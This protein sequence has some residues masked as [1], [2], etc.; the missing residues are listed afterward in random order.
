MAI[1][2]FVFLGIEFNL[3]RHHWAECKV[4]KVLHFEEPLCR[5]FWF[6]RHVGTL[7]E[8]HFI[9]IILNLFH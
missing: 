6:N 9:V 7:G 3:I 4:C 1:G 5:K 2:V 8:A